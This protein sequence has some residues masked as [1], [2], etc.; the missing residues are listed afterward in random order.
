MSDAWLGFLGGVLAALLGGIIASIVQR[1]NEAKRRVDEARLE[2]YMLLLQ[3]SQQYFWVASAELRSEKVVEETWAECR[4]TSWRIADRLR[5][6]DDVEH[7]D[8]ILE[9]LFSVKIQSA[10]DRANKLD[11][12]IKKLGQLVN[13][14]YAEHINKISI[15]NVLLIGSRQKIKNNAPGSFHLPE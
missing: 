5:A 15:E 11:A 8:E 3:L 13:P 4:Q 9:V 6:C 2:V 10:N 12:L 7:L 14:T 1:Q